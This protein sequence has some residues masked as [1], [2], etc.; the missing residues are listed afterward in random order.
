M[1]FLNCKM[2]QKFLTSSFTILT[3]EWNF[4]NPS[5][6]S[7]ENNAFS[8]ERNFKEYSVDIDPLRNSVNRSHFFKITDVVCGSLAIYEEDSEYFGQNDI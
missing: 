7:N 5:P 1:L 8:S 3:F 6:V 2:Y 4:L